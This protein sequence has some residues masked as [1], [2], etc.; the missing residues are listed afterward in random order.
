MK[1]L[2]F[3]VPDMQTTREVAQEMEDNGVGESHVHVMGQ[4]VD[5]LN[6][7]HLHPTNVVQTTDLVPALWRGA[8]LG[9][10]LSGAIYLLFSLMLPMEVNISGLGMFAIIMFGVGF[11]IWASG[12]I[13][14]GI[15]NEIIE[16]YENYVK[17]GHYIVIVDVPNEREQEVTNQV[18][19][20]HPNTKVA[21]Q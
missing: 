21:N 8:I 13:G 5:Q 2:F 10:I 7:A 18:I 3:L 16:R 12:M 9:V 1:R 19:Q 17:E 4:K 11:G 15:K 6:R 14:I 20:M